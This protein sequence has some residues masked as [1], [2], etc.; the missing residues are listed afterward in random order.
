MDAELFELAVEAALRIESPGGIG[1]L[2][3][4][5]LHHALKY[6]VQPDSEMHEIKRYGFVCDA[7]SEEGVFEIQTRCFDRLRKKLDVLLD[8]GTFTVV[9]PMIGEKRLITTDISTGETKIRKSPLKGSLYDLFRELFKI[10]GYVSHPNF[11]LRVMTLKAD[12]HRVRNGSA[13]RRRGEKRYISTERIPTALLADK[14]YLSVADYAEFLPNG[15]PDV[16]GTKEFSEHSGIPRDEVSI[17]LRVLTE[18]GLLKRIG[19]IGNAYIYVKN[20]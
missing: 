5:K 15:I 9:Y 20:I 2:S 1:T 13:K 3:E 6:Y 8:K 14:T 10:S 11:R 12:E 4:H 19:K 16:F 18:I 7:V 17:I